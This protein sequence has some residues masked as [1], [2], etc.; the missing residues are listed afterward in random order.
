HVQAANSI[1]AAEQGGHWF[2]ASVEAGEVGATDAAA[3]IGA[4]EAGVGLV[5]VGG[6]LLTRTA[7]ITPGSAIGTG[8]GTA[9]RRLAAADMNV[10]SRG[11]LPRDPTAA[12]SPEQHI[13]GV[14]NSQFTSATRDLEGV[15][16]R[17]YGRS[18][19]PIVEIDLSK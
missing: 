9:Y 2:S 8:T 10:S 5:R 17:G 7:V 4:A 12:I 3:V 6:R 14:R 18:N 1:L 16:R 15:A 13:L 19:Q 11:L